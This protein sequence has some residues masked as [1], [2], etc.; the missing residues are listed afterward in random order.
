MKCWLL[1][2]ALAQAVPMIA[3]SAADLT[4]PRLSGTVILDGRLNEPMWRAAA[5]LPYTEFKRWVADT[6]AIDPTP[7]QLCFFHD[8][9]MLYV[10]LASYDGYVQSDA[11]PENSDGLYSFS[12]ATPSGKLRH[13]RLRWSANPPVATDQMYDSGEWGARLRGPYENPAR[14]GGGYVFEFAIRLSAIGWKAGDTIPLNIIVNDRD[15]E[16]RMSYHTPGAEFARF[17]WGSFDNTNRAGYRS[18]TLAP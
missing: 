4:V 12:V 1:C 7:F 5:R 13:Y 17:A 2:A 6:Y 8:G 10:A 14:A 15:G 11:V 18:I 16:P 3:A 9:V